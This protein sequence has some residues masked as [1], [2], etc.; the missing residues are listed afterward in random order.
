[1]EMKINVNG[2][3]RFCFLWIALVK[4]EWQPSTEEFKRRKE[5]SWLIL[6][7]Q[8]G[9]GAVSEQLCSCIEEAAA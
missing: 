4:A 1:M 3:R 5:S 8:S 9:R 7:K 2:N 6:R